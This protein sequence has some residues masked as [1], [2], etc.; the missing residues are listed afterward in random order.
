[1]GVSEPMSSPNSYELA[2]S[3]FASALDSF[4]PCPVCMLKKIEP[5]DRA[6][7]WASVIPD[8]LLF[9]ASCWTCAAV[10]PREIRA[11]RLD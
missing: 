5:V 2:L 1:M 7:A 11:L 4:S 3:V 9:L 10:S 8:G 6:F